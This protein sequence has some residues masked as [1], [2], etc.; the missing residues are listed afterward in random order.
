ML[1]LRY[2]ASKN[3]SPDRTH[4]LKQSME[5]EGILGEKVQPGALC[6]RAHLSLRE[7]DAE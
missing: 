6:R 7:A 5:K 3:L 2:A 1:A 4:M